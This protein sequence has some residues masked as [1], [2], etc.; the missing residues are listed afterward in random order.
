[1]ATAS[2]GS[3]NVTTSIAAK[4][5]DTQNWNQRVRSHLKVQ[6]L[7]TAA[8]CQISLSKSV[9]TDADDGIHENIA[10]SNEVDKEQIDS[11]LGYKF[12]ND[13]NHCKEHADGQRNHRNAAFTGLCTNL[14][15]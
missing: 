11:I 8:F 6:V 3:S 13:S 7:Q 1:M 5:Q 15:A 4:G 9:L 12:C 10:S 14:G 2:L